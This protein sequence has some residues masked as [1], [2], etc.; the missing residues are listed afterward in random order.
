MDTL[1]IDVITSLGS[2]INRE[3]EPTQCQNYREQETCR[4]RSAIDAS[5][6]HFHPELSE[7]DDLIVQST[8]LYC[9]CL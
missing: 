7:T 5:A 9:S 1:S 6:D 3:S 2:A 4:R 8:I